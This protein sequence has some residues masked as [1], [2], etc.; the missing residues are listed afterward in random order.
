MTGEEF[1]D[2][3]RGTE[4]GRGAMA[5]IIR[6]ALQWDVTPSDM[7][8]WESGREEIPQEVAMVCASIRAYRRRL[9]WI[10]SQGW[11]QNYQRPS[12]G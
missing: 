7:V 4:C 12:H 1:Y 5:G 11:G 10:D 2:I 8:R 3:L 9:D 6:D